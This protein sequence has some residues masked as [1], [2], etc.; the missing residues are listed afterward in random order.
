M[1]KMEV[2]SK[3]YTVETSPSSSSRPAPSVVI[4]TGS[5]R[6]LVWA[7]IIIVFLLLEL[8]LWAPTR[9]MRNR[10][11]VITAIAIFALVLIDGL[12]GRSSLKRLGFRLPKPR[13]AVVVLG[14]G[15]AAA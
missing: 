3:T 14:M 10:W 15:F 5:R 2:E 7:E 8:A 6:H 13:G 11:A 1:G 12:T 9:T 4:S